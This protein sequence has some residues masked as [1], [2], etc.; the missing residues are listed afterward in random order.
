MAVRQA[1][2]LSLQKG[3]VTPDLN[4]KSKYG[5]NHVGDFIANNIIDND[6]HL[7]MNDENIGLGKSTII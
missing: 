5:T 2:D 7:N 4:E 6:D 3:I 1:V